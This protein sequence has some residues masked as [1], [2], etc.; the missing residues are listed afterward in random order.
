[1]SFVIFQLFYGA[2]FVILL[3]FYFSKKYAL[4]SVC[5]SIKLKHNSREFRERKLKKKNRNK[6]SFDLNICVKIYP[7]DLPMI[8]FLDLHSYSFNRS[9]VRE[10]Y[11]I[12]PKKLFY[13]NRNTFPPN[14]YS[15]SG[16]TH[17]RFHFDSYDYD[18]GHSFP[19]CSQK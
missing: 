5:S 7:F 4:L 13:W 18:C 3:Y 8:V 15:L 19:F 10:N 6:Q 1:M 9:M 17:C 11:P 14:I 2:L 12:L 16:V